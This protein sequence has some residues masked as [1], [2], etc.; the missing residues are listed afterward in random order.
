MPDVSDNVEHQLFNGGV[1]EVLWRLVVVFGLQNVLHDEDDVLDKLSIRL[2]HDDLKNF[3]K[4]L[5]NEW[6]A[7]NCYSVFV[8]R[9]ICYCL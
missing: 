3:V 1:A 9:L 6:K 7:E 5:S 8:F 2:I 4:I